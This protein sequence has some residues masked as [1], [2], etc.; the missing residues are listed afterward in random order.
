MLHRARRETP[1]F[2][3]NRHPEQFRL[4][5]AQADPAFYLRGVHFRGSFPRKHAHV[6]GDSGGDERRRTDPESPAINKGMLGEPHRAPDPPGSA[7][8]AAYPHHVAADHDSDQAESS[9]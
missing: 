5:P 4:A 3:R 2:A 7:R 6:P 9:I 8:L 1:P